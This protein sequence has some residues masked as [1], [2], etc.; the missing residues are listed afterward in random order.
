MSEKEVR[1]LVLASQSP[2]RK[3]LLKQIGLNYFVCPS[4][5]EE[6]LQEMPQFHEAGSRPVFL[7]RIKA[8]DIR[9]QLS[10][11]T[12]KLQDAQGNAVDSAQ[13]S[14]LNPDNTIILGADTIVV[15]DNEVLEKPVDEADA[16]AMLTKLQG[17]HH[18]VITGVTLVFRKDGE[19]K[20]ISFSEDTKVTFFPMT[21]QEV[22]IY[23]ST[24]EPMD[25]AG[26]YG[27]QGIGASYIQGIE[28]DYNNVVGLPVGR[29]YQELKYQGL[30]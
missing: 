14:L 18:E 24:K 20:R 21:Q 2:R 1:Y 12:L 9:R 22:E 26:A 13:A 4:H 28:G 23:V 29:L 11:G 17:N 16:K 19:E 3:E 5:A 6:D 27:I 15:Q 7:S 30:L 25:K 10:E 8:E